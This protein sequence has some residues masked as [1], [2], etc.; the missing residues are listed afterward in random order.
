MDLKAAE[1]FATFIPAAS[2]PMTLGI[3]STPIM[4]ERPFFVY[5]NLLAFPV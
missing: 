1:F 5:A 2:M 3:A 4:A